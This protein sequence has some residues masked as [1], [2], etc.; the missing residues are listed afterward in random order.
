M[1]KIN[2]LAIAFASIFAVVSCDEKTQMG[3]SAS[4]DY[5][6]IGQIS[7]D[8]TIT[9]AGD[10]IKTA[11]AHIE[12]GGFS[13]DVTG[14]VEP[15]DCQPM[16]KAGIIDRESLT[17]FY[18]DGYLG[19]EI[20][21][22]S[23][24][25]ATDK[26]NHHFISAAPATYSEDNVGE[27]E[28]TDYKGGWAFSPKDTYKWRDQ[29]NHYFWAYWPKVTFKSQDYQNASFDYTTNFNDDLV[30]AYHDQYWESGHCPHTGG[31]ETYYDELKTL[32]FNHLLSAVSIN[33]DQIV[34]RQ[35][36]DEKGTID[37]Q[38]KIRDKDGN[39]T[40]VDRGTINYVKLV[41]Y[42]TGS[43]SSS[44]NEWTLPTVKTAVSTEVSDDPKFFIPQSVAIAQGKE[45]HGE[46]TTSTK[47]NAVVEI[48]V[49]D[50]M[51]QTTVSKFIGFPTTL[52]NASNVDEW[53]A[54]NL[55]DYLYKGS[56]TFPY[57]P[58]GISG[59]SFEFKLKPSRAG[60]AVEGLDINHIKKIN[61]SWDGMPII[62]GANTYVYIGLL[63]PSKSSEYFNPAYPDPEDARHYY[64]DNIQADFPLLNTS[65]ADAGHS[66]IIFGGDI[67]SANKFT[68][69]DTYLSTLGIGNV[70]F[71][72]QPN[73]ASNSLISHVTITDIDLSKI[74]GLSDKVSLFVAYYGGSNKPTDGCE[75][76]IHNFTIEITEY[77]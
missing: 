2:I 52:T 8:P 6:G 45:Q 24:A 73:N 76:S 62:N 11:Q 75:W 26:A 1:K 34:L 47:N 44:T 25:S 63:D 22:A 15:Y 64:S 17:T 43:W 32:H 30:L 9:K 51:L 58:G 67:D 54:G 69:H 74:S 18:V 27:Y 37:E 72:P 66:Y 14:T 70:T 60:V 59:L 33:A 57:V 39:P 41:S 31:S 77:K 48:N 10:A 5:I 56:F 19:P 68:L 28:G 3:G 71:N 20:D 23:G 55:Y 12:D 42:P 16:T 38:F 36:K 13:L 4:G 46:P 53:L 65:I 49:T 35:K 7:V 40:T 50:N 61:L 21:Y 29:I